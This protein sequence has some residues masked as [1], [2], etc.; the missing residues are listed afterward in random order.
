MGEL[1]TCS[2]G[3]VMSLS[4]SMPLV[5]A[6]HGEIKGNCDVAVHGDQSASVGQSSQCRTGSPVLQPEHWV[7]DLA[8]QR[9]PRVTLTKFR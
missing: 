6:Y 1:G 8:G 9:R 5:C 2:A 4:M 7:G 3:F